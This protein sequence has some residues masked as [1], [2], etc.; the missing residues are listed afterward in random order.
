[1]KTPTWILGAIALTA[2]SLMTLAGIAISELPAMSATPSTTSSTPDTPTSTPATSTPPP[3]VAPIPVPPP[4][5]EITSAQFSQVGLG[6]T[7]G[8]VT[9]L[10]GRNGVGEQNWTQANSGTTAYRWQ[11][12]GSDRIVQVVFHNGRV[13]GRTA[14]TRIAAPLI[15]VPNP[16]QNNPSQNN[17]PRNSSSPTQNPTKP[18]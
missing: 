15:P 14:W 16:S 13:V 4:L 9:T 3:A 12:Q 10:F 18:Q 6:M 11:L 17:S 7:L 2:P 8:E 5:P 1:M